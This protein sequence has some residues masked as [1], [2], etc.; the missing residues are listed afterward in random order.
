MMEVT[1][2]ATTVQRSLELL[3]VADFSQELIANFLRKIGGY[4]TLVLQDT[5]PEA[6]HKM[7][8][9]MR[10]LR[11]ILQVLE[12]LVLLPKDFSGRSIGK[13]AKKMGAVRDLDVMKESLQVTGQDLP[14]GEQKILT[15]IA[16][17][18]ARRRRLAF[19]QLEKSLATSYRSIMKAGQQW[20][21]HPRYRHA[22]MASQSVANVA[23]D[24]LL[25]IIGGFFLHGGWGVL[26]TELDE[27]QAIVHDL[28]KCTK[29]IRYQTDFFSPYLSN[30]LAQ[31]LSPLEVGQECLGTMQDAAVLRD[32]I[33][34]EVGRKFFEKMPVLID[35]LEQEKEQAWQEWQAIREKLCDPQWRQSLRRAVL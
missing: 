10:R 22:S 11:T 27:N 16:K 25:P 8:V 15:K 24:L 32:F 21:S 30:E 14:P 35:R 9:G 31:F 26:A 19:V 13:L 7:R 5:E 20:T 3:T 1:N 33:E 4:Q 28:R 6:L 23:P 17:S 34:Q 12:P 2:H 29:R 18:L